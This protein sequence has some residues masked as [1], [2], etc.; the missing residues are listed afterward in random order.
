MLHEVL[1][2]KE[3]KDQHLNYSRSKV[4]LLMLHNTIKT[5]LIHK[6]IT[7]AAMVK[8]RRA[9]RRADEKVDILTLFH[10]NFPQQNTVKLS[11]LLFDNLVP[12]AFWNSA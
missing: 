3:D 1:T 7:K 4:G 8:K 12:R 11:F 6:T 9:S 2:V 10:F 5:G